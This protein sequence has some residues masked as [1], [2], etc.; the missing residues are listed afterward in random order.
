[1]RAVC[2]VSFIVNVSEPIAGDEEVF[3]IIISLF[4]RQCSVSPPAA[5]TAAAPWRGPTP[6]RGG[7]AARQLLTYIVVARWQWRSSGVVF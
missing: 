4:P 7:D 6:R 1:M 2:H 5:V 3:C